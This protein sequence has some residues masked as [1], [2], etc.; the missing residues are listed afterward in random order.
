MG[1]EAPA[2]K[3]DPT[4]DPAADPTKPDELDDIKKNAGLPVVNI[5]DMLAQIMALTPEEQKQVLAYLKK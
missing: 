3:T 1:I 5:K 2:A 4:L